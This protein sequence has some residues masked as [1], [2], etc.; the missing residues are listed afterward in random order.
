M[1]SP[2]RLRDVTNNN[3]NATPTRTGTPKARASQPSQSTPTQTQRTASAFE[4]QSSELPLP[5]TSSPGPGLRNT[6]RPVTATA[7][8]TANNDN[9]NDSDPLFSQ[10]S[11]ST[12]T[13]SSQLRQPLRRGDITPS[14]ARLYQ[15]QVTLTPNKNNHHQ[16]QQP[17]RPTINND[18]DISSLP[19]APLSTDLPT[20]S[21]QMDQDSNTFIWGT[22]VNID[23]VRL[24]FRDFLARFTRAYKMEALAR[25][26]EEDPEF[27]GV[28]S[29]SIGDITDADR[30]PFYPRLMREMKETERT[31]MNLDCTNLRVYGATKQLYIQ[32]IRYPQE[33]IP[34]MDHCLS[35]YWY[36]L[37]EDETRGELNFTIRPFNLERCVNLRD[38]D[39]SDMDQ[40]VTVRG[41][42]IR[43]SPVIPD[44]KD[45]FFQCTNCDHSVVVENDRG[46]IVEPTVCPRDACRAKNT[47]R[48]VHNRCVFSDKQISRMQ[49]TP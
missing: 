49:E 5:P 38:L 29:L 41:L 20:Q 17:Q 39:P 19:L 25:L 14:R 22:T 32:L 47:M 10:F 26:K 28:D 30:E 48:L 24:A 31:S 46:K 11:S 4:S 15:R 21:Q 27:M 42:M 45:G 37:F 16:Q 1:S 3:N 40:L 13:R 44:M 8:A 2:A 36:E 43:C 9:N 34:I 35:E 6:Q 23:N 7:T 18:N 33:V 12:Q